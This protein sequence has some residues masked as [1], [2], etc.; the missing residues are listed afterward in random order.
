MGITARTGRDAPAR[1]LETGNHQPDPSP[2]GD[3]PPPPPAGP[4][5]SAGGENPGFNLL[6]PTLSP[7]SSRW[8]L[9]LPGSGDWCPG[10]RNSPRLEPT[11]I[12]GGLRGP[13]T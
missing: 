2:G 8:T 10:F 3:R 12:P 7:Q 9:P 6:S 11:V 4:T 13:S 5:V 1:I